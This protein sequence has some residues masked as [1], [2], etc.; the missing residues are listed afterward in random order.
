MDCAAA[1]IGTDHLVFGAD[2]PSTNPESMKV[3]KGLIEGLKLPQK[4]R[5]KIFGGNAM[6]LFKIKG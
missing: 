3:N 6:K 1:T 4:E 2:F 5:D